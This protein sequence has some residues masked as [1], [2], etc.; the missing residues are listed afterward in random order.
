MAERTD[1]KNL[2]A[3]L[4]M[5]FPNFHPDITSTPNT[6]DV[7]L[8][9]LGDLAPDTLQAAVRSCCA[10]PGR[11]FAP[12][13]GEI[14]GAAVKLHAQAAGLPSAAEAWGCIMES[15]KHTSFD[16]P[17][18]LKHPMIQEAVRC[19]GGM[20]RIGLSEDN[21]ADRAHFLKIY[22]T[23]Y[24]Q[25]LSDASMLPAVSDYIEAQRLETSGQIKQLADKMSRPRLETK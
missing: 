8:D 13:A 15:F 21:M 4:G 5:A 18:L 9:L 17:E 11:A 14:R 2:I 16:Q 23:V 3:Y 19:M 1:I 22:D 25:T 10:E 20:E 12:S 24:Q 6:V 7:M